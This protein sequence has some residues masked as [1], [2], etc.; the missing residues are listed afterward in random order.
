VLSG[1]FELKDVGGNDVNATA[2]IIATVFAFIFGWLSIAGL[3]RFLTRH[4]VWVFVV[5]RIVLGATV[6][7]LAAG[8]VID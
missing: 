3:L 5:Y 7:L 6:L 8:S 1:L 2:T 4:P